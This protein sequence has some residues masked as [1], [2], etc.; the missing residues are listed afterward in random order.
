MVS[1]ETETEGECSRAAVMTFTAEGGTLRQA[2]VA[3]AAVSPQPNPG[4]TFRQLESTYAIYQKLAAAGLGPNVFLDLQK[5]FGLAN[6][7]ELVRLGYTIRIASAKYGQAEAKPLGWY[8]TIALHNSAIDAGWDGGS[9]A[10][11]YGSPNTPV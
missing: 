3:V 10:N 4:S 7:P 9:D 11:P 6:D 5:L 1:G 8:A 2:A